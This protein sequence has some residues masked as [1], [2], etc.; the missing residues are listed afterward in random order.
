MRWT[1]LATEILERRIKM[2]GAQR[3]SENTAI[4]AYRFRKLQ[5]LPPHQK[6]PNIS[7][8]TRPES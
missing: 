4:F 3:L 1:S 2:A 5:F 6:S 7:R 8:M